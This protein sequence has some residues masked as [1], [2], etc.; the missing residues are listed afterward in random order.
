[1]VQPGLIDMEYL[2]SDVP[3]DQLLREYRESLA[4][5]RREQRAGDRGHVPSRLRALFTARHAPRPGPA[6]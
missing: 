6:S 1:M 2:Y 4:R 5:E 3:Q